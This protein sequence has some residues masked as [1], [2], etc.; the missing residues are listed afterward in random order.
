MVS[1]MCRIGQCP[2]SPSRVGAAIG[3]TVRT[4]AA[5]AARATAVER[6]AP[7]KIREDLA[8]AGTREGKDSFQH[9][10]PQLRGAPPDGDRATEYAARGALLSLG[11]AVAASGDGCWKAAM[12]TLQQRTRGFG[13]KIPE[14]LVLPIY[15]NLPSDMQAKIFEPTPAGAR[16]VVLATNI[17]ETSITIDNIIY[18]IDPGF[19]KPKVYNPRIRV[20]SLLV[21]PG[22]K[23]VPVLSAYTI[24]L[25][26]ALATHA[27]AQA[28]LHRFSRSPADSAP[29]QT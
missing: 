22:A 20:E 4:K 15:A 23:V 3:Q 16:K 21:S 8:A 2:R 12:E 19:A 6:E 14:L 5:P 28:V 13:T 26:P 9:V 7:I 29:H 27:R 10:A 25:A 24:L 18:V 17:A 11:A 1:I